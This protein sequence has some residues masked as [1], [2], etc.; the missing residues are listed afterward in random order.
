[1]ELSCARARVRRYVNIRPIKADSVLIHQRCLSLFVRQS[2]CVSRRTEVAVL[3]SRV[4][5]NV[6]DVALVFPATTAARAPTCALLCNS[7]L[8][9]GFIICNLHLKLSVN[10]KGV[11]LCPAPD[12]CFQPPLVLLW[13]PRGDRMAEIS[14]PRS[15]LA[16]PSIS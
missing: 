3:S 1:M 5:L 15:H 8:L 6:G 16:L 9:L 14:T 11:V 7:L 10:C 13:P 2:R 4:K 12:R